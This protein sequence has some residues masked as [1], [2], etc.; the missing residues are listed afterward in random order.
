MF[1]IKMKY[2]VADSKRDAVK[3]TIEKQHKRKDV[4]MVFDQYKNEWQVVELFYDE[5]KF[6][7]SK[8]GSDYG[9][10]FED[11]YKD[12]LKRGGKLTRKQIRMFPSPDDEWW[13]LYVNGGGGNNE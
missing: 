9:D 2:E 6:V 10:D 3:A 4:K 13:D 7:G 1:T 12:Y 5:D 8:L 11:A